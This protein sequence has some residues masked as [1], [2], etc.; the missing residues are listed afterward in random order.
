M[1]VGFA[2]YAV[3]AVEPPHPSGRLEGWPQCTPPIGLERGTFGATHAER[4]RWYSRLA[5]AYSG[6]KPLQWRL[7]ERVQ[8][9]KPGRMVKG[10][11]GGPSHRSAEESADQSPTLQPPAPITACRGVAVNL[12]RCKYHC[13]AWRRADHSS[14]TVNGRP[15]GRQRRSFENPASSPIA[16]GRELAD[17]AAWSCRNCASRTCRRPCGP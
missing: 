16:G 17:T 9:P 6:C 1:A 14:L 13:P 4:L 3:V 12:I 15:G 5:V 7:C 2:V 8:L 11:A 10:P